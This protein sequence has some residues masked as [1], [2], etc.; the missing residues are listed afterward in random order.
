MTMPTRLARLFILKTR[1]EVWVVIYALAL[2]AIERGRNYLEIY[3]GTM[4]MILALAC[5]GVVFLAGA[6]LLDAVTPGR[7]AAVH[8]PAADR[9][10]DRLAV[11]QR[12]RAPVQINRNRPRLR[13][14]RF[15]SALPLSRRTAA[16]P[17]TRS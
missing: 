8:A 15:G 2:G 5:T 4:G 3:P 17:T 7:L 12:A 11:A 1:F 14:R 13:H 6:K 10:V 9:P 16:R